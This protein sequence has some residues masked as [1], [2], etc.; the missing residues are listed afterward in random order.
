[1]RGYRP[2]GAPAAVSRQKL[3]EGFS[4]LWG[5]P[6][7]PAAA[8]VGL[9]LDLYPAVTDHGLD[10]A[11]DCAG[12]AGDL[13]LKPGDGQGLARQVVLAES[14]A[15]FQT[16][17]GVVRG[18]ARRHC[19]PQLRKLDFGAR[20]SGARILRLRPSFFFSLS[21]RHGSNG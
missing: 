11:P 3:F 2:K 15:N 4:Q 10:D 9:A 7:Q 6:D 18:Q 13:A 17:Q 12:G 14:E 16:D 8:V 1:M 21:L 19:L 5:G 20:G